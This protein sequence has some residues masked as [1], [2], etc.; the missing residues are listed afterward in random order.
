MHQLVVKRLSIA[1]LEAAKCFFFCFFDTV[2]FSTSMLHG[3]SS[4][5]KLIIYNNIYIQKKQMLKFFNLKL[6]RE[7]CQAYVSLT[8]FKKL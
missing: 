1:Q 4:K 7:F 2:H 3:Y 6:L 5:I 8:F